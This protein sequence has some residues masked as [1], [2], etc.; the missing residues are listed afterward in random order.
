[1]LLHGLHNLSHVCLLHVPMHVCVPGCQ[2]CRGGYWLVA[3]CCQLVL[4]A[5]HMQM[6]TIA[7]ET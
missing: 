3:G 5:L 6:M 2:A 7:G 4:L 1:M